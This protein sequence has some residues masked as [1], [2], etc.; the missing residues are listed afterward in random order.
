MIVFTI[1]TCFFNGVDSYNLGQKPHISRF[2]TLFCGE[3]IR[4]ICAILAVIIEDLKMHLNKKK[5]SD[6]KEHNLI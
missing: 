2:F 5:S 3:M 4:L 6:K 1:K